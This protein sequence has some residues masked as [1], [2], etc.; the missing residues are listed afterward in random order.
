MPPKHLRVARTHG[1]VRVLP[2]TRYAV[3]AVVTQGCIQ[4]RCSQC[5]SKANGMGAQRPELVLR[6]LRGWQEVVG[7][8]LLM[9]TALFLSLC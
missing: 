7:G 1:R 3:I 9:T 8:K 5:K 2:A 6:A 4:R